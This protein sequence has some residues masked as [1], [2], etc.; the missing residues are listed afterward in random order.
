MQDS[1][2]QNSS[3]QRYPGAKLLNIFWNTM[4][5]A[6]APGRL[7]DSS[8]IFGPAR[9]EVRPW[10]SLIRPLMNTGKHSWFL[11]AGNAHPEDVVQQGQPSFPTRVMPLFLPIFRISQRSSVFISG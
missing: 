1:D 2:R 9:G 6:V 11:W 5:P 3:A 4:T 8:R 7:G 10:E